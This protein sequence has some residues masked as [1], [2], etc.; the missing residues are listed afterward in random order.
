VKLNDTEMSEIVLK[1]KLKSYFLQQDV[2]SHD[3][4]KRMNA[5]IDVDFDF[6]LN[7]DNVQYDS[8]TSLIDHQDHTIKDN[9]LYFD[10]DSDTF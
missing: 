5:Y 1:L 2:S 3:Y 7:D 8:L 10:S 4:L 6:D 9:D